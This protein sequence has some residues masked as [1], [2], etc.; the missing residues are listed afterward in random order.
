[1]VTY[2]LLIAYYVLG[3]ENRKIRKTQPPAMTRNPALEPEDQGFVYFP[4][5]A[6]GDFS[7]L[8]KADD[9]NLLRVQQTS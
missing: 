6:S 7:H 4:I 2:C 3:S 8:Q 5:L 9:N 1:M